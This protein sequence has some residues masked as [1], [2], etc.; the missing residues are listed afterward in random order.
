[1][2]IYFLMHC[3]LNKVF[4]EFSLNFNQKIINLIQYFFYARQHYRIFLWRGKIN[5]TLY[6]FWRTTKNTYRITLLPLCQVLDF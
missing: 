1:M 5:P 2:Y 3:R 4:S 6:I